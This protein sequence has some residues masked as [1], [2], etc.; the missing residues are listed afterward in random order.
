MIGEVFPGAKKNN[1]ARKKLDVTKNK[2]NNKNDTDPFTEREFDDEIRKIK[3][4]G[5]DKRSVEEESL[6]FIKVGLAQCQA[7][8]KP[9]HCRRSLHR[10]C[11]HSDH[12]E[13]LSVWKDKK[14]DKFDCNVV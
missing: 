1:S 11:G 3:K 9:I 5:N 6:C 14:K 13:N 2:R 4:V 12:K 8:V 7:C 10:H